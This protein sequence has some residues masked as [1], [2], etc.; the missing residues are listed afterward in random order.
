MRA[1]VRACKRRLCSPLSFEQGSLHGPMDAVDGKRVCWGIFLLNTWGQLLHFPKQRMQTPRF[2][3]PVRNTW[4]NGIFLNM[5]VYI[6]GGRT[7]RKDSAAV[8][9][10]E[11]LSWVNSYTFPF[12]HTHTHPPTHPPH[13][14]P[15][16]PTHTHTHTHTNSPPS[17]S[18]SVKSEREDFLS[19]CSLSLS[20]RMARPSPFFRRPI[21]GQRR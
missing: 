7:Q 17:P 2:L 12:T 19:P 9:P 8:F 16:P 21:T 14:T 10:G 13:P 3:C 1:C 20:Q 6:T 4:P 5:Y 15:P 18:V 11:E